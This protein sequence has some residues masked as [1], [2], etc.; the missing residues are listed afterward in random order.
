M[1]AR[2]G[3]VELF[4]GLGASSSSKS[5]YS[6]AASSPDPSEVTFSLGLSG[7]FFDVVV[8]VTLFV[9]AAFDFAADLAFEAADGF[10]GFDVDAFDLV[11]AFTRVET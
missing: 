4:F 2:G 3:A 1:P 10:A 5:S 6:S 9:V 8:V 7:F 11:A